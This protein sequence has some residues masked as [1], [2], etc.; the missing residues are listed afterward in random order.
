MPEDCGL[1]GVD[2]LIKL[3][4]TPGKKIYGL[5]LW[6]EAWRRIGINKK[7]IHPETSIYEQLKAKYV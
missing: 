1:Y 2:K 6:N 3:I 5:H 4:L 7:D